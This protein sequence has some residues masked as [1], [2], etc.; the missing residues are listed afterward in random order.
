MIRSNAHIY[1]VSAQCKI[2]GVARSSY[3]AFSEKQVLCEADLEADIV[4]IFTANRRAYGSRRIRLALQAEGLQVSRRR[5]SRIMRYLGLVSTHCKPKYQRPKEQV[6]ESSC[7]DL[8][9]RDFN[10]RPARY[11]FVGDLTYVKVGTKWAYVCLLLDLANREIVGYSAG[12][13]KDANLVRRAFASF[14]GDLREVTIFHSDRGSENLN[15][16][17]DE[18]LGA[19]E[20]SRSV[21]RKSNPWDNAVAESMWN[22]FKKE[23]V[24]QETFEVIADL[25]V[26]LASYVWWY[27]NERLHSSLGYVSPRSY[28]A[29]SL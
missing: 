28:V 8:L 11:V 18:L 23:F 25:Q 6:S 15:H 5:V 24:R 19:F 21:S 29:R 20:I 12:A 27:N 17:I 2:L 9:K 3:Y 1:S 22:G 7:P 26:K 13:R 16:A 4:R 10:N 14:R